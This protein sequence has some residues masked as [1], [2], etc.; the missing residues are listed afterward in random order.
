MRHPYVH[1]LSKDDHYITSTSNKNKEFVEKKQ[2]KFSKSRK[3]GV[4]DE[5]LLFLR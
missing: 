4:G 1:N 5:H 3:K 2:V